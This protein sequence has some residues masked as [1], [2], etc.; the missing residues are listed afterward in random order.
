[1]AN[2]VKLKGI[3]GVKKGIKKTLNR[4]RKDKIM[5]NKIGKVVR[6]TIRAKVRSGGHEHVAGGL[7]VREEVPELKSAHLGECQVIRIPVNVR[8]VRATLLRAS[9]NVAIVESKRWPAWDGH[10]AQRGGDEVVEHRCLCAP[11]LLRFVT[12]QRVAG[13]P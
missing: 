13:A 8:E 4:A 6:D 10:V 2:Q 9:I 11:S 1:M 12:A 7:V 3:P 5:L